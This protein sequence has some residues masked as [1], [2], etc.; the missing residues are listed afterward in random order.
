MT[1]SS[2]TTVPCSL[3]PVR[4]QVPAHPGRPIEPFGIT[5]AEAK[6]LL[7]GRAAVRRPDRP[8]LGAAV[9]RFTNTD[10]RTAKKPYEESIPRWMYLRNSAERLNSE[11]LDMLV[12]ALRAEQRRRRRQA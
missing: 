5:K 10:G 2:A 12:D 7:N 1:P 11:D 3:S 8:A 9:R 4:E 6:D